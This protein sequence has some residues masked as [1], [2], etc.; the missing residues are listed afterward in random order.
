MIAGDG[1]GSW[2]PPDEIFEKENYIELKSG[3]KG[4][5]CMESENMSVSW[6]L[7][8]KILKLVLDD[9]DGTLNTMATLEDG[10]IT[11]VNCPLLPVNVIYKK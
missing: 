8:G 5:L 11:T 6:T 3:G 4:I 9:D 2:N 1:S 10:V 7:E